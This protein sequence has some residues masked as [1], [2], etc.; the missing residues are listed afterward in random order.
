MKKKKKA[1]AVN[2]I[3]VTFIFCN[4]YSTM[5]IFMQIYMEKYVEYNNKKSG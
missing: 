5:N 2:Y 3:Y 4:F 1:S